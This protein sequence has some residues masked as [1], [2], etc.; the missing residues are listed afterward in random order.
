MCAAALAFYLKAE[1]DGC[2]DEPVVQVSVAGAVMVADVVELPVGT[3]VNAL[4]VV[5][6]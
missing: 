4:E 6:Q 3:E 1:T 2:V 5:G